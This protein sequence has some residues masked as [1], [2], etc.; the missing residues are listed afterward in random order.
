MKGINSTHKAVLSVKAVVSAECIIEKEKILRNKQ[1][2]E[3]A[4]KFNIGS[5]R[6]L[7][8]VLKRTG[9]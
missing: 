9:H 3:I 6:T 4:L 5:W 7:R 1:A 8:R 2:E